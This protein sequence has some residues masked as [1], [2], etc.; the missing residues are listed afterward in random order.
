MKSDGSS[1]LALT[2]NMDKVPLFEHLIL[3]P[4]LQAKF[5]GDISGTLP[6]SYNNNQL[7]IQNAT[8][9][10]SGGGSFTLNN[11][12]N[13][14]GNTKLTRTDQQT[15][16]SF[17]EPEVTFSR[18]ANGATTVDF[19]LKEFHQKS[20]SNEFEFAKPKGTIRFA[21]NPQAPDLMRLSNFSTNFFGGTVTINDFVYDVKK[22]EGET[23]VQ[24]SNMPLQKLLDLQG[25]KK[26]YATGALK[27]NIPIKLT[28]GKVEIP[29]GALLSQE[30][31]QIIYATS[32]EERAAAHQSLRTTYDVLSNFLYQQ[33][34]TTLSMTPDGQST[35]AIRLKGTNPDMYG[36][37]PIELN[38]NVQQNLLDLMRTLSISSEIEQA[39]SDKTTQQKK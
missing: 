2:V 19:A 20:G 34:S 35:L 4:N 12:T 29:D 22:Q 8:M 24:L 36:K 17:K 7:T 16:Y 23:T 18:L 32:A 30:S 38:L 27:G 21:E 9:R 6:I 33:L 13:Q 26:V 3:P 15:T 10:S 1:P 39:I 14:S 31:G 5:S 25:T 11:R 28:N 37:R